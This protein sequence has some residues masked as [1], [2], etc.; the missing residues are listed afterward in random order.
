MDIP[1]AVFSFH[2]RETETLQIVV[3]CIQD[4]MYFNISPDPKAQSSSSSA[5]KFRVLLP[6]LEKEDPNLVISV[7]TAGYPSETSYNGSVII[8]GNFFIHNGNENNP[9]S[10][11]DHPDIGK[12]LG[13]NVNNT[14]FDIISRE[15]KNSVE[16][17]FLPAPR[18]PADRPVCIASK[19]Y[20]AIS[21]INVT[22]YSAYNW[23]DHEAIEHFHAVEKR[24]PFNSLETT[25]G[26][27]KLSTHKPIIFVSAITDRL[28]YFDT[29][30]TPAQNYVAS[31]NAGIVLGQLFCALDTYLLDGGNLEPK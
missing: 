19:V 25:H 8:G 27:V 6:I 11:L 12:L 30:V 1:R 24:M 5:E 18:N 16:P 7:G 2:S 21:S 17:K 15:F 10:K 4:V 31:F 29:E 14:L 26:V 13:T 22:D 28:A 9:K 20:T 3:W 23:V